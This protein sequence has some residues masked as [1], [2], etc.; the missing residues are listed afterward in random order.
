MDQA[1]L[2]ACSSGAAA[3]LADK[4]DRGWQIVGLKNADTQY[5]INREGMRLMHKSVWVI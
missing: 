1:S 3:V 2:E 5:F 4:W